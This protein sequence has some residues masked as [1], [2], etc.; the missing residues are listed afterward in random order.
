MPS[1]KLSF[2]SSPRAAQ[3]PPVPT[4]LATLRSIPAW[5]EAS[6]APDDAQFPRLHLMWREDAG[7]VVHC[8]EDE[9]ALGHYLVTALS[10]SQ[11]VIEVN[12]GGQALERWPAELFVPEGHTA[13]AVG[14]FLESGKRNPTQHWIGGVDFPREVLWSGREQRIEWERSHGRRDD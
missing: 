12:L 14:Y 10:L 13:S 2:V 7:F 8:I 9:A 11:P 3:V 1:F 4:L 5:D 6:I